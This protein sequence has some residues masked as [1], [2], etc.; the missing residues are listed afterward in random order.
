MRDDK[1]RR[2]SVHRLIPDSS[3]LKT[4]TAP[5][6]I[7][8]FFCIRDGILEVGQVAEMLE[9]LLLD[10]AEIQEILWQIWMSVICEF[11]C[12]GG[13]HEESHLTALH[14]PASRPVLSSP[15]CRRKGARWGAAS[16]YST[17]DFAY[18]KLMIESPVE[19]DPVTTRNLRWMVIYMCDPTRIH[20]AITTSRHPSFHVCSSSG[21]FGSVTV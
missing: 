4:K 11:N 18:S 21:Q 1:K 3:A 7:I 14:G 5:L 12:G 10:T 13:L 2:P 19:Y 16:C 20:V 8:C 9:A 17:E 15:R 6:A